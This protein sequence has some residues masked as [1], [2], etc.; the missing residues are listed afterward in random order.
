MPSRLPPNIR[1]KL[2]PIRLLVLDVDGVLTDGTLFYTGDGEVVKNFNARDGLGIRLLADNG[3]EVGI[4]TG[5]SSDAVAVRCADLG[6]KREHIVLG[7]KDKE[8]DLDAM[9][10]S[11]GLADREFAAMGDDL[12]DLPLL[13]R[14][15]FSF[16]PGDAAP[17]VAAVCDLVTGKVGGRGAV[18]EAAEILLKAQGRWTALVEGWSVAERNLR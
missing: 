7:S 17:E 13:G 4:I 6:V 12:P 8:A 9:L 2:E 11:L 16:C 1:V 14:A 5:R 10:A 3:F 18:R 15:G